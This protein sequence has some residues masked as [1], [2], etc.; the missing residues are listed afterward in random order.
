MSSIGE[1]L[2]TSFTTTGSQNK[3]TNVSTDIGIV[4]V[5]DLNAV[6]YGDHKGFQ[7]IKHVCA[8]FVAHEAPIGYLAFGAGG[9][10]LLTSSQS[11]TT[12]HLFSIHPHPGSPALGSVQ[13][14]YTLYRG[15]SS[16]KVFDFWNQLW[17]RN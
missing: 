3:Q 14:L 13:H 11:A 16:A 10:L 7:P 2:V 1:S 4:T 12:F 17:I 6:V 9:Q 8:H 15:N 5:L